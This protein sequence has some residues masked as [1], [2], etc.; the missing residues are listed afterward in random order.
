MRDALNQVDL[1]FVVDTTGS[2]SS[3]LAAARIALVNTL[4][5]LSAQS[6]LDLRVALVEY[7]DHPPQEETF[8]TRHYALT[9]DLQLVQKNI[10]ALYASG[11]GDHP[12]AVFDG[13]QEAAILT[14]WRKHS[15]R[16]IL[17]VG[18]AP[19]HGYLAPPRR[20]N[21]EA[22][23]FSR[24]C[25]CGLQLAQVTAAA[26]ENR[27]IVQSLPVSADASTRLAFTEIAQATGGI[28]AD[29]TDANV[30]MKKI[31]ALLAAEF[32]NLELDRKVLEEFEKT[33]EINSDLIAQTVGATRP[34]VA[35][36]LARLG[37]RGFL[38]TDN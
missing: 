31:E 15:A 14:A 17:L 24:A 13:V 27:A 28:C 22:A 23:E 26:E 38:S 34:Q 29:S 7:R 30:V 5:A 35:Q 21:E 12:E 37:K 16:F 36:S 6:H 18:D 32:S 3:F 4:K 9:A 20:R 1:C 10:D 8:V 25:T 19:P 11:G 2:M 33:R